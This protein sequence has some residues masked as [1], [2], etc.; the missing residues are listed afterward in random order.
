[1]SRMKQTVFFVVA[2]VF[3]T[4]NVIWSS[5]SC[6]LQLGVTLKVSRAMIQE[7]NENMIKLCE[8]FFFGRINS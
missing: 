6:K 8:D 5:T 2:P 1:M 4:P 3:Q 7:L